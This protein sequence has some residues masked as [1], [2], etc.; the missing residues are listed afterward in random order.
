M[1]SKVTEDFIILS[2]NPKSGSY[3]IFGNY[4]NF[5]ILGAVMMDL[6]L[7]GR[8]IFEGKKMSANLQR[9]ITGMV[10]H[11][12]MYELMS[13]ASSPRRITTW[14]KRLSFN[15][16][17]YLIQTRNNLVDR[18]V[19]RKE[20]RRFLF[21]PYSL[22]FPADPDRRKRLIIRLK[23]ILLYN[24]TPEDNEMMLLGLIYSCRLHRALSDDYNERRDIR[25]RLVK[26]IKERPVSGISSS[27]REMQ[28][29]ISLA[30]AASV[31]ASSSSH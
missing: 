11:D 5:G 13:K 18:A 8:I 24:K 2:L 21:I 27:I 6:A 25:K 7:G 20:R 12:R 1:D 14:I 31:V 30:I 17:W 26:M 22:H 19:L 23:D 29:A 16:R 10:V 9:G 15:S 3:M 28:I 4:L